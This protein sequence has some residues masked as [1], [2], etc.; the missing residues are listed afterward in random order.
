MKIEDIAKL[1]NVSKSAVSLAINGKPGVSEQTRQHILKII[2][3]NNYVPLRTTKVKA[4]NKIINFIA[5]KNDDIIDDS[6]SDM[7]FFNELLATLSI[8]ASKR[9]YNI[10]INTISESSLLLELSKIIGSKKSNANILL[11]TNLSET[12]L[13]QLAKEYPDIIIIDNYYENINANF[14]S[15]NN[16]LAGYISAKY[17][18]DK[19][20]SKIAYA[21]GQPRI[22]NFDERRRGFEAAIQEANIKRELSLEFIFNGMQIQENKSFQKRLKNLEQ[23]PTA[24]VCENDYIAISL[25]KSLQSLDIKVPEQISII[26]VDNIGECQVVN[27]ELTTITVH[28]DEIIN[29]TLNLIDEQLN[30]NNFNNIHIQI[31]PKLIERKSVK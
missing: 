9:S 30:S 6:F 7:P 24:F 23:L 18:I 31:N 17:L 4:E 26:G 15:I 5:C 19:G 28:K 22:K 2:E 29:Q 20:H 12:I 27:P 3:E 13:R 8:E 1:A 10:N 16:S 25:L 11:G 21:G 14:I